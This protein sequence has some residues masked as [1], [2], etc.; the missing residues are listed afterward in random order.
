MTPFDWWSIAIIVLALMAGM[1]LMALVIRPWQ[2]RIC[3]LEH[4]P[5]PPGT[6]RAQARNAAAP[7][8][9]WRKP[10]PPRHSVHVRPRS[11]SVPEDYEVPRRDSSTDPYGLAG[12]GQM[13]AGGGAW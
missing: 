7:D 4:L 5:V 12:R 6:L 13:G 9:S 2:P 11:H 10:P 8:T 3:A 1:G